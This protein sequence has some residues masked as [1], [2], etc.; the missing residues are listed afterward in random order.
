MSELGV[1]KRQLTTEA[2]KREWTTIQ[3]IKFVRGLGEYS[4]QGKQIPRVELLRRYLKALNLP[5]ADEQTWDKNAVRVF[6]EKEIK[7]ELGGK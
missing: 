4:D 7:K 1:C 2:D 6:V 3:E 5:S